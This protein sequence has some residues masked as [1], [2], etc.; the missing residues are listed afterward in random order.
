MENPYEIN[1]AEV[2]EWILEEKAE[3]VL[4]QAPDGIKPYLK[5]LIDALSEKT[6]VYISGSHAW[7]GC[8]I[9]LREAEILGVKHIVHIGHHGP[10]RVRVPEDVKVY[11]VPAFAKVDVEKALKKGVEKLEEYLRVGLLASLQHVKQLGKIKKILETSG[12]EVLIG[13]GKLPYPGQVIGCDV[14]AASEISGKVSCFLVV[15]GG[16]F[17][18]LGVYVKTGVKTFVLDPYAGEIVDVEPV[19]KR[20]FARHLYNLTRALEAK[21]FGVIV[22]MKPGQYMIRQALETCRKIERQGKKA[23]LLILDE[24]E[25]EQLENFPFLDAYVNTACPRLNLDNE[26]NFKKPIIGLKELDYILSGRIKDYKIED[27]IHIL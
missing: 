1:V 17:H 18:G 16:F 11:F 20:M 27:A 21:R 8:D 22:S 15:A 5:E 12:H 14:S 26:E 4:I 3:K 19:A 10:V 9:A 6:E 25:P 2:V 7:G 23:Y 13:R 24:V